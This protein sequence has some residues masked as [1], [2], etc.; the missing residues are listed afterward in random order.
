MAHPLKL[1]DRQ[2]TFVLIFFDELRRKT[3]A[4]KWR[5]MPLMAELPGKQVSL[6]M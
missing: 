5:H 1:P 2:V 3:P 4:G 6:E